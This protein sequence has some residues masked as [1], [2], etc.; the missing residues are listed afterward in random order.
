MLSPFLF[1][2]ADLYMWTLVQVLSLKHTESVKLACKIS[3]TDQE[4]ME[5]CFK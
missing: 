3:F 2:L 1:M 4:A 5:Q